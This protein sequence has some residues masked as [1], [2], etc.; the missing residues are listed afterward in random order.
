M[1]WHLY[2]KSRRCLPISLFLRSCFAQWAGLLVR[3]RSTRHRSVKFT[4]N[5][6][7]FLF[8]Y[9]TTFNTLAPFARWLVPCFRHVEK[10]HMISRS[11]LA[12]RC[13]PSPRSRPLPYSACATK[14][15]AIAWYLSRFWA[16]AISRITAT[17]TRCVR[18]KQLRFRWSTPCW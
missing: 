18:P 2:L 7:I 10:P 4:H 11:F 8:G 12:L 6:G 5:G 17:P 3:I 16:H 1:I 13:P 14:I 9:Q 15:C